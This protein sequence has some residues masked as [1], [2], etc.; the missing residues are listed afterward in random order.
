MEKNI[1][2]YA[3]I[4]GDTTTTFLKHI[5]NIRLKCT[6]LN[7]LIS[8]NG[9]NILDG[10]TIYNSLIQSGIKEINI[11]NYGSVDSAGVVIFCA[12]HNRYS[13]PFTTFLL[14]SISMKVFSREDISKQK[15]YEKLK[16][17]EKIQECM[18][19]IIA[20]T[21]SKTFEEI[22]KLVNTG[23]TFNTN[24]AKEIGLIK[25]EKSILFP[26]E[27]INI[28]NDDSVINLSRG[29]PDGLSI[30]DLSPMN[31]FRSSRNNYEFGTSRQWFG[32][33]YPT[34]C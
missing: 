26:S 21:T 3:P 1:N 34:F 7:V 31:R 18:I 17:L 10:I 12:G 29:I 13:F 20:K 4:N 16:S 28:Y 32:N 30:A 15:V 24:E 11:Y 14:H 9:G 22:E 19:E 6:K 33:S 25:G 23:T 2:F 27:L 8:T 5:E